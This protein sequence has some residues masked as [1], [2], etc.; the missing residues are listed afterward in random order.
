MLALKG[1]LTFFKVRGLAFAREDKRTPALRRVGGR[2]CDH[3]SVD[4]VRGL[5]ILGII[6][7]FAIVQFIIYHLKRERSDNL[8]IS[9]MTMIIVSLVTLLPVS[10]SSHFGTTIDTLHLSLFQPLL[11]AVLLVIFG[12][13]GFLM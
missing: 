9:L 3:A 7:A 12:L 10:L 8:T 11:L 4:V 5:L 2:F 6:G 1:Q 13:F